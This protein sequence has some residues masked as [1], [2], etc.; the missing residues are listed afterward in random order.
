[1]TVAVHELPDIRRVEQI[2][3]LPVVVDV[4]DDRGADSAVDDLF[5]WLRWVDATFSTFKEDSEISRINRGELR[6]EDAHPDVREVLERCDRLREETNG[7]FDMRA[8]D[9]GIDPSG[10]VKGWAV[11]RAAAI[12]D[13]AGLHNYAVSAGG[14]MRVRGRAVPELAWRVGIQHPLDQ[15]QVAAV[16]ESTDLAIA[17]SGAYARGDHVWNPHSGRAPSGILSVTI[18]GPELGTA[19]AYATA[20]FA[21]GPERAPHWTA[22][23]A[24]YEAMTILADETVFKT[25]GFPD[26]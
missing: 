24:G 6:R 23:L 19:D 25:G 21:M 4:R 16:V 18:V 3:G 1:M 14:D 7:Y 20:A 8:P 10:L 17:T 9:G 5:D 11:D 26:E 22:R 12:L 15:Q 2:M 13:C